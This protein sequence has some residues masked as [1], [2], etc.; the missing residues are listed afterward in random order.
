MNGDIRSN[1]EMKNF[2]KTLAVRGFQNNV[3]ENKEDIPRGFSVTK[4]FQPL[5]SKM[6]CSFQNFCKYSHSKI[7]MHM[8]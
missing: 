6:P 4:L 8:V 5:L 3:F 1:Y 2:T 7:T